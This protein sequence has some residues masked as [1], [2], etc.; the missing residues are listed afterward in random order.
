[1]YHTGAIG[2]ELGWQKE[3]CSLLNLLLSSVLPVVVGFFTK[4]MCYSGI[5]KPLLSKIVLHILCRR[6]VAVSLDIQNKP[7]QNAHKLNH[8]FLKLNRFHLNACVCQELNVC[9]IIPVE[10]LFKDTEFSSHVL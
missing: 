2:V 4:R 9:S 8:L 10:L 5:G 7:I 3:N 6:K 1:M